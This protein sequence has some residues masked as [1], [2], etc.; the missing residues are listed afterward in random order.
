MGEGELRANRQVLS[1]SASEQPATVPVNGE[2]LVGPVDRVDEQKIAPFV[3]ALLLPT[4]E[5]LLIRSGERRE[6]QQPL[7]RWTTQHQTTQ[8]IRNLLP[9]RLHQAR[10][11]LFG[12]FLRQPTIAATKIGHRGQHR[13]GIGGGL[14]T[15]QLPLEILG[16]GN[17]MSVQS[18]QPGT[19]NL[20]RA[21]DEIHLR[22]AQPSRL[23]HQHT[24]ATAAAV[25][26]QPCCIDALLG[27]PRRHE[28]TPPLP[29]PTDDRLQRT[30][31]EQ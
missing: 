15:N 24:H 16:R 9:T 17:G 20:Q 2:P 8:E 28:Q 6:A 13:H 23:S 1:R 29:V 3:D 14:V 10:Q 26:E 5:Q 25:A 30:A 18:L 4:T 31:A 7:P 21:M 19:R 11:L 12:W 22:S 27:G